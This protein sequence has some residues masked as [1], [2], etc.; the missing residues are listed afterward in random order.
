M[1]PDSYIGSCA[2]CGIVREVLADRTM[3]KHAPIL[4]TRRH[5]AG[6]FLL[7]AVLYLARAGR[8]L[9]TLD[10]RTGQALD[11]DFNRNIHRR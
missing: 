7:P 4:R 5:C 1:T 2:V 11:D 10:P 9:S 6:S 3:P 8:R